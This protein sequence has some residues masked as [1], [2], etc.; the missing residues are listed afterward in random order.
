MLGLYYVLML[1]LRMLVESLL[2]LPMRHGLLCY[3]TVESFL[4]YIVLPVYIGSG[5]FSS[6][7]KI[8]PCYFAIWR[9]NSPRRYF[10]SSAKIAPT[11]TLTLTLILTLALILTLTQT[12]ENTT[13]PLEAK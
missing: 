7:S 1:Q 13:L 8:A 2:I 10:S 4:I 6:R 3:L 5:Y 12:E 9:R 11:Q